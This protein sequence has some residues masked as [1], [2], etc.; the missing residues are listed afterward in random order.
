MMNNG[1][2]YDFGF[3]ATWNRATN[4]FL[5]DA[6]NELTNNNHYLVNNPPWQP[7]AASGYSSST[8]PPN[9]RSSSVS[10]NPT[11]SYVRSTEDLNAES[12]I[13]SL[14]HIIGGEEYGSNKELR[15]HSPQSVN[16]TRCRDCTDR[17]LCDACTTQSLQLNSLCVNE[18]LILHP[19]AGE[20]LSPAKKRYHN[21]TS[22]MP[23]FCEMHRNSQRF[24]C[25]TCSRPFC[26]DCGVQM[27]AG[28]MTAHIREVL[29]TAATEATQIMHEARIGIDS[30]RTELLSA[31]AATE[32]L[33]QKARTAATD[34]MM[35]TKRLIGALE[36]RE[37]ELL[38]TIETM[39]MTKYIALKAREEILRNGL[40]RLSRAL[41]RLN[42][43]V[44]TSTMASNPFDLL[45]TK[46][47]ASAEVFQVR[48]AKQ[49]LAQLPKES[50]ISFVSGEDS[51]IKTIGNY[52]NVTDNNPGSIGDRRTVRGRGQNGG[53]VSPR[54]APPFFQ[55]NALPIIQ[56]LNT[57]RAP[58]LN[59]NDQ[60]NHIPMLTSIPR[61]C[62]VP[63]VNFRVT[64]RS[65]RSGQYPNGL[66]KPVKSIGCHSPVETD[67]LCRPWGVTCDKEGNIVVADRS[68]NRIQIFRQDGSL[69]RRFGKHGKGP[70]EFDRPAGVAVD[71]RRRI[72]VADKDNHRIQVLTIEG[73]Y[74]LSFGERGSRC[75]QF[76]YPWDVAVN[77]ECQI[78]VSDTRN[79]RVQLFSAEGIFLRKYGFEATPNVWKHF[80]SPRGVAFDP[81]G[82]LIV[83]DFNNHRVVMVEPDYLNVRV[84]VP[85]SYNGVKQ[86]LRPQGLIVDDEGNYIISDSRHHRIQIF[87]S[88]GVL[89][90]KYGKYGT[91]LDELDRPSGIALTPDGRIVVVDF[92]NN[93]V[94]LI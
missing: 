16:E 93:R 70:V 31:E 35:C 12:L 53:T 48:H 22:M 24:Y 20:A 19:L 87:N 34:V 40:N 5:P 7:Y 42:E 52:G 79:H 32:M 9:S 28:H 59:H 83:T 36:E 43:L 17:S 30:L 3:N 61:G 86:F 60:Y 23:F 51:V 8:S 45:V 46:D 90:W 69:I 72:I 71:G 1:N 76:N 44:D 67:N 49:Y 74:L 65:G 47:V 50:W 64:V 11:Q 91:G 88:A 18:Q 75:G 2:D 6:I 33:N 89:K 27:H 77:S 73:Q 57:N 58:N 82:N 29:D 66:L 85:E 78:A 41:E 84:V 15:Q 39:R 21:P 55:N 25:K 92:G 26:A 62:A 4:F 81:Q 68:N 38:E 94:M 10:S 56:A 63:A 37:K 80:D 13:T 14:L 54:N